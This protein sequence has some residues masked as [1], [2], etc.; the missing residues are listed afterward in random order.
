M[1]GQLIKKFPR[2]CGTSSFIAVC[3]GTCY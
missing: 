1:I 2:F 3:I